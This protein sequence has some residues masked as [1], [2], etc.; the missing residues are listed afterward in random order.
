M[1]I[2]EDES[3]EKFIKLPEAV[4]IVGKFGIIKG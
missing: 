3:G 1:K 2:E 4:H